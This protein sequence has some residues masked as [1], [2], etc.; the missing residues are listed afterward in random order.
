MTTRDGSCLC[1]AVRFR[2][3]GDLRPVVVCHCGMCQRWHGGPGPYT[4]AA[5]NAIE[6]VEGRGLRWY[7]SSGTAERG[8]C[9]ECGSSLFWRRVGAGAWSI[10]AGAL[11]EPTGLETVMHIYVDDK[12]D[13][14][15]ITD[16]L[17]Q[18]PGTSA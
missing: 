3:H 2:A 11:A 6:I 1:G 4:N 5:D 9:A 15:Q 14:Y 16:G 17:P 10:A 12:P 8:F 7:R 13:Y 18:K